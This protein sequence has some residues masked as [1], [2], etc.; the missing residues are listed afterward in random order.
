[1]PTFKDFYFNS[2]TGKNK[3][4]ARMCVPDA[5]PRAIVQIIHGIAEYIDRYDEFM[6][7][8]ADNGI[9]AVGTD[10]LGHGKSIESEEQTGFFAYDNGWDYAV[11]DEEV[12]RLA[13][14]ENYPEL[15]IIVFG[16]SMGSFMARTLLIRYPDAFNA[17]IISGTGNQ[18]AAL[19]NGGLFMGNLV[20][21]LKGA[22]HYSKFLNNLAFGSYNK[23]YDNPKTE[24]DWLSRDEANVQKYIDDPLCGF[25]PSCSL[26]RDMMTGV[27][28]ITNKKNLTAMN[29]DMPVYFM[30]GDMDPVGECG[31]GVQKAYNNFLEAG[32]KDVSIK[33][34]PGGR[35]EMLNEINKDEVYTDILAWLDSK[36]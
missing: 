26:F 1:M 9:I 18:G 22:H 30:S 4:H 23:I 15:P 31:K 8:L 5:E 25:I 32:M 3:I 19:V 29:K 6:S 35:H 16:H 13:M 36:I 33:L 20:T 7:F 12:L 11:R 27:K 34:Y 2:S 21:G 14:H 17:A 28:F 24:Y 10:H